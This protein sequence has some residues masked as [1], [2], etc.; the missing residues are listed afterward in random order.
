M[1]HRHIGFIW[2]QF[3][4]LHGPIGQVLPLVYLLLLAGGLCRHLRGWYCLLLLLVWGYFY[5]LW[6]VLADTVVQQDSSQDTNSKC[7]GASC[8]YCNPHS[9]TCTGGGL[10]DIWKETNAQWLKMIQ[11]CYIA[12]R[13]W[14]NKQVGRLIDIM[15]RLWSIKVSFFK[16]MPVML[17][18]S[19]WNM[20]WR[21][22]HT[23]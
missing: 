23:I 9:N 14:H 1:L 17:P 22:C 4:L 8:H 7:N 21:I 11:V 18:A 5:T 2:F 10:C 19:S 15:I 16:T 3:N 20:S 6:L 13:L 12:C